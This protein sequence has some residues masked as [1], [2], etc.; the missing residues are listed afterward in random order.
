MKLVSVETSALLTEVHRWSFRVL[1]L[2]A[3]LHVAAVA[4][5]G[6]FKK[7]DVM[8]PMFTGV[9]RVPAAFLRERRAARKDAPM[10]RAAS[11]ETAHF[12]F[13]PWPRA[14]IA[15]GAALA[16]VALLVSVAG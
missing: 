16:L 14:V 9:K 6:L 12:H 8:T 5:H 4:Y 13:P 2:L 7:D 10:R 3:G 1:A 11:R 15:F